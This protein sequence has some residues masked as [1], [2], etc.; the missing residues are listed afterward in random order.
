MDDQLA[1]FCA[2][3]ILCEIFINKLAAIDGNQIG[4][5]IQQ[6]LWQEKTKES[7]DSG[8][9]IHEKTEGEQQTIL[10]TKIGKENAVIVSPYIGEGE[11]PE[12]QKIF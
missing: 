2:E 10:K 12:Q 4:W 5:H 1:F 6:R 7:C 9:T 8:Q 11:K 3:S